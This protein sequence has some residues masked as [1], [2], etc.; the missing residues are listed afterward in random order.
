MD[1]GARMYDAQLGRWHVIDNKSEKYYILTPY[2]YA[3]NN[4]IMVLDPD[5]N[6]LLP[7]IKGLI[8][9][10]VE[11]TK[12]AIIPGYDKMVHQERQA[13]IDHPMDAAITYVQK[14]STEKLAQQIID[15]GIEKTSKGENRNDGGIANAIA[16][17]VGIAQLTQ[18][19]GRDEAKVFGDAHEGDETGPA[20]EM[21]RKNNDVGYELGSKNP[22]ASTSELLTKVLDLAKQGKL[23]VVD[24]KE[25]KAVPIKLTSE[26]VK[27]IEG[28]IQKTGKTRLDFTKIQFSR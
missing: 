6:D 16:H 19:I 17:T 1:Y 15:T 28:V 14:L 26:Q 2:N 10:A 3:A 25:K 7:L 22:K 13:M 21:D 9:K 23:T 5:G 11:A 20:T 12:S 4:P 27:I 24:E 8:S 18:D